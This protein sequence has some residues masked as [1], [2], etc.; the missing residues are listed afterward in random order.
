MKN[1]SPVLWTIVALVAAGGVYLGFKAF[2]HH[3]GGSETQAQATLPD[4]SS[5]PPA[6]NPNKGSEPPPAKVA[7][8]PV[9]KPESV[10]EGL[11]STLAVTKKSSVPAQMEELKALAQKPPSKDAA[12]ALR[13]LIHQA[14]QGE[15]LRHEALLVLD[16]W[17]ENLAWLSGDLALMLKDPAQSAVWRAYCVQHLGDHYQRHHDELSFQAMDSAAASDDP[18]VRDQS[19]YSLALLAKEPAFQNR[20]P[21]HFAAFRKHVLEALAS[22]RS[23][24]VVSGLRAAA[25]ASLKDLSTQAEELA[26]DENRALEI[27][28]AAV[29]ALG[30]VGR[31]ESISILETCARSKAKVL[32]NNAQISISAI[33]SI[34]KQ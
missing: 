21:E 19:I 7:F 31:A 1:L 25:V 18:A 20:E 17:G 14:D 33:Q 29:Q 15:V 5:T 22:S 24:S 28:V 32:A 11:T 2:G 3:E 13:W 16:A 10:P 8:C 9:P 27:R 26:K 4:N 6:T 34:K 23:S 12:E 30:A